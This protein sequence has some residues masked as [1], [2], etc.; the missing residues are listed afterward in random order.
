MKHLNRIQINN[1]SVPKNQKKNNLKLKRYMLM[2]K[3]LKID[4][5]LYFIKFILIVY[6]LNF[7]II[8]KNK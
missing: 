5:Y 8:I 2:V 4:E 3:Y 6:N 1:Y 7:K